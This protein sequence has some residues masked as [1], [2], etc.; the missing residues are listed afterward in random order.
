MVDGNAMLQL[1]RSRT[2]PALWL[3]RERISLEWLRQHLQPLPA[4]VD[5]TAW[6]GFGRKAG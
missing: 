4:S 2:D 1:A 6:L 5:S 3:A